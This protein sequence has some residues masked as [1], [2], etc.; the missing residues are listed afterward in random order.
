MSQMLAAETNP[1]IAPAQTSEAVIRRL[2]FRDSKSRRLGRLLL[3]RGVISQD[4]LAEALAQQKDESGYLG[5][6]LVEQGHID[7]LV[8][9][10]SLAEQAGLP[11][12]RLEPAYQD[13]AIA[14]VLPFRMIKRLRCIPLFRVEN[15]HL[16]PSSQ[17]IWEVRFPFLSLFTP[18]VGK[19]P[20]MRHISKT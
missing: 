16:F 6:I 18:T 10:S 13:P 19:S 17:E 12:V 9:Y 15:Y 2:P 1:S 8:L 3:D 5:D 11:F 14:G 4:Q 20:C 7:Q